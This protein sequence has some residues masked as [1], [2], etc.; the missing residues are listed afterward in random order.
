MPTRRHTDRIIGSSDE[1]VLAPGN[2]I[3]FTRQVDAAGIC[4]P[5]GATGEITNTFP[6]LKI[7][8]DPQFCAHG[9]SRI[10]TWSSRVDAL[11]AIVKFRPESQSRWVDFEVVTMPTFS[12]RDSISTW[13]PPMP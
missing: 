7:R 8:V 12:N 2:R 4:V 11:Y 3:I 6:Q 9:R 10:V 1:S 5:A 13:P